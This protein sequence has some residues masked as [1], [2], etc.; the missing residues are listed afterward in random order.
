[1]ELRVLRYFLSVV[2]EKGISKAADA[3][4]VT[5][6]TLSRQIMDLEAELGCTL[7]ERGGHGREIRL[8]DAGVRF[9]NRAAEIVAL[10]DMTS[11]EFSSQKKGGAVAGDV[12]IGAGES[13][14]M[15]V[16]AKTAVDLRKSNPK[17]NFNL[18]SGNSMMLLEKLD[19]GLLDFAVVVDSVGVEK[20]ERLALPHKDRCG[21]LMRK[22]SPLAAK[23]RVLESD[24]RGI[25]LLVS[26]QDDKSASI[27]ERIS[28]TQEITIAG[29]YN[30]LYNAAV[31]VE[32]GFGCALCIDGIADVSAESPLTF[33]PAEPPQEVGWNLVWRKTA[34][35][36]DAAEVFLDELRREITEN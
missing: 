14:V 4:H 28:A 27:T 8:T 34:P 22:D 26:Q 19:R 33:R 30:L 32:Q 15:R 9:Y 24:L 25:P 35:L 18:F 31:M 3:L 17:V 1:M 11:A 12:Y 6:P 23:E 16:L 36:S 2:R 10:A 5:Q 21:V 13:A 20:Y 29:T 7:L